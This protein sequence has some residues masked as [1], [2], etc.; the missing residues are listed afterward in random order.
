MDG[1]FGNL[2]K[3]SLIMKKFNQNNIPECRQEILKVSTV[4]TNYAGKD[5][6][7][8][9]YGLMKLGKFILEHDLLYIFGDWK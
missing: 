2:F 1:G 8:T 6:I 7:S 3:F 5:I 4:T 9:E